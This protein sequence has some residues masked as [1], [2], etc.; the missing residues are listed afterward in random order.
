MEDLNVTVQTGN[1]TRDPE[2]TSSGSVS[3]TKIRLAVNGRRK[4]GDE[5]VDDV[6]YFN[7]TIFGVD[8]ENALKYLKKGRR[9]L[10]EGR[11]DWSEW[12]PE[13]SEAK[14]QAVE[15]IARKVHYLSPPKDKDSEES[16]AEDKQPVGVGA[17][18]G[19]D[20]IPF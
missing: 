2:D 19:E 18:G 16:E 6:N 20:D 10:V 3:V 1:L 17:G 13:D 7:V 12:T 4:K 8:A 5:W 9:V 14:R 15:I 11:L